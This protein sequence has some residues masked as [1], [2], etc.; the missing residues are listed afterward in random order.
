M[1]IVGGGCVCNSIFK[2]KGKVIIELK[3]AFMN[4]LAGSMSQGD[5]FGIT[6]T[7]FFFFFFFTISQAKL[8]WQELFCCTHLFSK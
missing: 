8:V 3:L 1:I 4:E 7:V 6:L 5:H 2:T